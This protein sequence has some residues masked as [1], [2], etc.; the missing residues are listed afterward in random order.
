MAYLYAFPYQP[1]INNPNENVRFYMTAAI[2]EEGTYAI[3]T[4]RTRWGWVN[5]AGVSEG[6]HFQWRAWGNPL[7]PGHRF[8]ENQAYRSLSEEGLFGATGFHV[9]AAV[10]LLFDPGYGLFALT[11]IL[12]IAP[13]GVWVALRERTPRAP[14]S[15]LTGSRSARRL[16][17]CSYQAW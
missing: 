13:L 12:L 5:D 16:P 14:A 11:P 8:L 10:G 15:S 4:P 6:K 7:T 3:D 9:E 1:T 17:G 2:V